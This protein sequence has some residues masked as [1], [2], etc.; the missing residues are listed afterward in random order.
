[1]KQ[2][3]PI[4]G[5]KPK[6]DEA[7]QRALAEAVQLH[8]A[9]RYDD[10]LK[11]VAERGLLKTAPGNSIAGDVHLK[12]GDAREAL[13]AFDAAVRLAPNAP[14]P[15]ANRGAALLELGRHEEALAAL[16]RALRLRSE[17]ANAH[18]NRGNVLRAMERYEDAVTAYARALR[19]Q[20]NFAEA[21]LNRGLA[22]GALKRGQEA[23]DEF[24][25]ALRL[26]PALA[27]AQIG[28]AMAYRD[29]G[30]FAD[31]FG[32]IDSALAADPQN[33]DGLRFRASL[34]NDAQRHDEALSAADVLLARDAK[35]VEALSERATALLKLR[36]FAEG[37][38][39][40]DALIEAAPR[41]ADAFVTRG[42]ILAEMGRQE[43]SL[44]AIGEAKRLGASEKAYLPVLALSRALLGDTA[45]A[46]A[47]FER[48][49][50]ADPE[51]FQTHYNRAFLRLSLGDWENGW[52]DHEWRLKQHDHP[53][54]AFIKLAPKWTGEP[55]SG[56]RLLVYGEQGL[57]DTLQF[58]RYVPRL[59]AT[60][61][62]IT[63][64]I[65]PALSRLLAPNFPDVDVTGNVGLR[66][67]FDYQVSLMSLPWAFHDTMET[68]PAPRSYL[69]ADPLRIAKWAGRIGK[70][71]LRVGIVWQGALKYA[72]DASRSIPLAKF[73]PLADVPGVRLFS[74]QAQVGLD[75][76]DALGDAMRIT[77]FGE[78][79]EN[80]PDGLQEM[81]AIM[82]NLDLLVMSDTAPTHLAGALGRPTWVA[83]SRHPDWRWMEGRADTPWYPTMRLFRQETPGDWDG[84][85]ARIARELKAKVAQRD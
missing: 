76:L 36:R 60:G 42:A 71:G 38:A 1:M 51:A 20:P 14:E 35:D 28:R 58:V 50:A 40:T 57:G 10:A 15:Y 27:G 22:L 55:V 43:E 7:A 75:Q 31:A 2:Q 47:D 11:L 73:A 82:A 26:K 65:Q 24:T 9:G 52:E 13:K 37:L 29:M 68:L 3:T 32:A 64:S 21:H 70:G 80:N 17:Y 16:D 83:L 34:L 46:L 69:N 54:R 44:A 85:F 78:E 49:I 61:A 53:H 18:F 6:Y 30:Q 62:A 12:R 56:K 63:L 77:R 59:K 5:V 45:A 41:K 67:G 19:A 66:S 39:A 84:V 25:R 8:A 4:F 23:L 48:A 79:L 33:L 74:V 72:R 81:A